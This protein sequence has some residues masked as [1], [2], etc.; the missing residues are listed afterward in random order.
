MS[1]KPESRNKLFVTMEQFDWAQKTV[2]RKAQ[3]AA[4]GD[5]TKQ[6]KSAFQSLDEKLT[7][8]PEPAPQ[9][10]RLILS[11]NRNELRILE[12]LAKEEHASLVTVVIPGY[13]ERIEKN[14]DNRPQYEEYQRAAIK[15]S[16]ALVDLLNNVSRT[17][18]K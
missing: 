1:N 5:F 3:Q 9:L 6:L 14:P 10:G 12:K 11:T 4:S 2:A 17:L 16:E 7:M 15:R 13:G 18:S 8:Q